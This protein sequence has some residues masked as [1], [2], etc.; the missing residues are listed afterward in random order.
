MADALAP[1]HPPP[2]PDQS[3]A[4]A[5]LEKAERHLETPLSTESDF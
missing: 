5:A 4:D 2:D 3:A 1:K